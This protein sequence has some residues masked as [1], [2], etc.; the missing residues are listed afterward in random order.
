[1]CCCTND[2][3]SQREKNLLNIYNEVYGKSTNER[4][5]NIV[6]AKEL[7]NIL[8]DN[9]KSVL[10][11]MLLNE[12]GHITVGIND[13]K[14]PFV[15]SDNPLFTM[16]YIWDEKKKRGCFTIQLLQLIA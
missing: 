5:E 16:P 15:T 12:Y 11:E 14:I 13:T 7:F 3:N 2:K 10:L 1:M 4:F 9:M 8:D 6:F